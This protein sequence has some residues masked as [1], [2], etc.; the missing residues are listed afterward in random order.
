MPIRLFATVL[1]TVV[2]AARAEAQFNVPDPAPGENF[3]VELGLMFWTPTPGIEI[4]TGGLASAGI[5][6]V[7]FVREFGLADDTFMEF[8]SVLK[9][10][11]KHKFRISHINFNYNETTVVQRDISFG[12]A[13]FP[14]L[15]P[16]TADLEWDLW[17]FGWEWD[18]VA[19]DRGVFGMITELKQNHLLADLSAPGFGTEATDVTA[20]IINLGVIARVYPHRNI[21]ITAEYTGFKLFGVVKTVA[22]RITDEDL[23]AKMQDFDIYGT[24]N[25]GRHVGAQVGYRSLTSEYAIDEDEGDLSMKGFYFGGLVRF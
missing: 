3:H 1:F 6:G 17:R 12:G 22:D 13:T 8:R 14:I 10:G 15:I 18:F 23:E 25:F 5:P 2:I 20:P 16:V 21:A 19:G 11:R 9:A 7:D 4:Q 24:F